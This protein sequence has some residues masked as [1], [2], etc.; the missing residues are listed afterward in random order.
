VRAIVGVE[1]T[2]GMCR[3]P[4][5][6]IE[7]LEDGSGTLPADRAAVWPGAR[8]CG[9][10]EF[11]T[12]RAS[13]AS[14][15][16]A[17]EVLDKMMAWGDAA[18]NST[19]IAAYRGDSRGVHALLS[20]SAHA[21]QASS[22]LSIACKY[23]YETCTRTRLEAAADL[24]AVDEKGL[25]P[26]MLASWNGHDPCARLLIA[27]G[28]MVDAANQHG[29]TALLYA[30]MDGHSMCTRSLLAAAADVN[31]AEADGCTALM[32]ACF[33]NHE[34]CV[35]EMCAADADM[36]SETSKG[37]T[38]LILACHHGHEEC[39]R[40]MIEAGALVNHRTDY[41]GWT[42]LMSAAASGNENCTSVLLD[43]RAHVDI[44]S[45][46]RATALM[47]SCQNGYTSIALL[48]LNAGAKL[49]ARTVR[50][51]TALSLARDRQHMEL[52]ELLST[53]SPPPSPSSLFSMCQ[54]WTVRVNS[55]LYTRA[56]AIVTE[57]AEPS[58]PD[59]VDENDLL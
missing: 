56:A 49:H 3:Q 22:S 8:R 27:A 32:L 29:G 30:C 46:E 7:W 13:I 35:R 24:E 43:A 12:A 21:E 47:L 37:N 16:E 31:K 20:A 15:R 5:N 51:D 17:D 11:L 4:T 26:L 34:A 55:F 33:G 25:T 19:L 52:V 14:G 6:A 18:V 1:L 53:Y 44:M 59:E 38:A 9:V 45:D 54:S 28:A 58:R 50:G 57:E 40:S 48:L 42:A 39:A 23:G 10:H 2:C 41:R 36:E